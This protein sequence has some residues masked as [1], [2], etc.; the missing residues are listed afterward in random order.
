MGGAYHDLRVWQGAMELTL[1]IY[2]M[3]RKFP[4]EEIYGL[5]TQLR[6]AAVSVAS[7][8]AEGNDREVPGNDAETSGVKRRLRTDGNLRAESP[9]PRPPFSPAPVLCPILSIPELANPQSCE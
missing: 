5:S 4:A 6:R 9:K 7:N 2:R 1:S 3:T 8:I